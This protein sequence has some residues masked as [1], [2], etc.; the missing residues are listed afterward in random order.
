MAPLGSD[1]EWFKRAVQGIVRV[2][3]A[4]LRPDWTVPYEPDSSISL[5]QP[6]ASGVS[7]NIVP[8]FS[9]RA[10]QRGPAGLPFSPHFTE[11]LVRPIQER[12]PC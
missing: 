12:L 8:L 7:A 10:P 9:D 3:Q 6:R 4:D 2:G 11:R 1:A 5:F